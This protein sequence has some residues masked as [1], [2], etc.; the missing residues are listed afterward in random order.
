M[1]KGK[2][3]KEMKVLKGFYFPKYN[4]TVQAESLKEATEIVEK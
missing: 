1:G 3:T 2:E 4:R